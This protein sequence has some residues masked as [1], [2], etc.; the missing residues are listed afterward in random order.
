MNR[1]DVGERKK[2]IIN[3]ALNI[4]GQFGIKAITIAA[5][6]AAAN[7]STATVHHYFRNVKSLRSTVCVAG[8]EQKNINVI[9]HAILYDKSFIDVLTREQRIEVLGELHNLLK[10]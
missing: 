3:A 8:V 6:A 5:V 7:V 4:A 10:L 9:I 2:E 1:K